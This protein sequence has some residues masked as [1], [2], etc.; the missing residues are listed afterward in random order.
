MANVE[1]NVKVKKV[2]SGVTISDWLGVTCSHLPLPQYLS[3]IDNNSSLESR[4]P[5]ILHLP[6]LLRM[7]Q[8]MSFSSSELIQGDTRAL[9]SKYGRS[10][11]GGTRYGSIS[12]SP[13]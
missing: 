10:Y 2:A 8:R 11:E 7:C 1:T 5:T 12:L 3:H 6:K 13:S 4:G 9:L